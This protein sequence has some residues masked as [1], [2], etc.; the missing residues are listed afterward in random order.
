MTNYLGTVLLSKRLRLRAPDNSDLAFTLDMYSRP[1]VMR[2]IGSGEVQSTREEALQRLARYRSQFGPVTGVWLIERRDDAAPL[3]FVLMK[4]IPFSEGVTAEQSEFEIGWHL[5]PSA[6]GSGF[7]SESAQALV[8]HARAG[9]LQRLV[10]VT[11]PANAESQAVARRLGMTYQGA[12]D[13]YYNTTCELFT[14]E[15]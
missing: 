13:R 8:D 4:P 9:G 15:L 6:W 3:G 10:A 1:E 5:H 12:T 2:Y 7:A 14:L 11:N